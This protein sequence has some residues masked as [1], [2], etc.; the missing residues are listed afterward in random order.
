MLLEFVGGGAYTGC[1]A[2]TLSPADAQLPVC[3][4]DAPTKIRTVYIV[5]VM[6]THDLVLYNISRYT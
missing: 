2:Y 1:G 5:I 4:D 3:A 6:L